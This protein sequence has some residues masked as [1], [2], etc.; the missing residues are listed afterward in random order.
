MLRRRSTPAPPR[1]S[2]TASARAARHAR[3]TSTWTCARRSPASGGSPPRLPGTAVHYAVKANP[4][5]RAARRAG[6]G[7]VPVRRRQPG[8]GRRRARGRRRPRR[9]GLLQPGQAPRRHRRWPPALGVRLFVVDSVEEV[10]EGRRRPPRARRCCAGSSPRARAR[11]GRCPAS[12][13]APPTR[14][15][16]ILRSAAELGLDAG[17]RLLPRRLAAAR[18][19]GLGRADR[20]RGRGVRRAR[21][22]TASSRWLLDLGGGFPAHL[23]GGCPPLAGVRRGDRAARC[24]GTSATDRPADPRRARPRASSPTPARWSPTVRRASSTAAAPAG[25]TS[26][27]ASSPGWS[28]PST[29]RSATGSRP[30]PTAAPTGPCVLAGPTCDSA[31]VLYERTPVQLP[32]ALAEGDTVRLL[33]GRRLHH[34]LLHRRLQRLRAAAD[35]RSCG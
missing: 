32:L 15:S 11:T 4:R 31:D 27:P 12:T 3:R 22:P 7:R 6:R 9:P 17:R 13:A 35:P 1:P 8:R 30:A 5:P 19:A 23:E 14:P 18:P 29:R 26:T 33:V 25:S 20:R 28:R 10:A 2:S 21:A 24:A 34:L 16:T